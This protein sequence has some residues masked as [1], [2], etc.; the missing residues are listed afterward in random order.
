MEIRDVVVPL[1]EAEMRAA[2][3]RARAAEHV[4]LVEL[5]ELALE[6]G[7]GSLAWAEVEEELS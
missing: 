7:P 2:L 3:E 1:D 6:K 4:A 5:I